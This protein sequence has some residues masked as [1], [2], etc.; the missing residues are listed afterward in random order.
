MLHPL[1][2]LLRPSTY[3][4]FHVPISTFPFHHHPLHPDSVQT[5]SAIVKKTPYPLI[6]ALDFTIGETYAAG[7]SRVE[8][9]VM[10]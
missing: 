9:L 6:P 8:S 10:K 5:S 1:L 7:H 3:S 2:S 4:A